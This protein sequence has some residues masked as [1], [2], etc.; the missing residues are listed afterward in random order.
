MRLIIV[1]SVFLLSMPAWAGTF[2]DDFEDGNWKGWEVIEGGTWDTNVAKQVSVVEGVL[3]L[4]QL[5]K[6]GFCLY[7]CIQ[8]DWKDYSFSAD[9]QIIEIEPGAA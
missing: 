7:F 4:D 2:K 8:K 5:N 9:M 3:S 6:S 1:L